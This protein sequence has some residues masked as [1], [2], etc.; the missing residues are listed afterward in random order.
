VAKS[1]SCLL[2]SARQSSLSRS[3][4]VLPLIRGKDKDMGIA[5]EG[6]DGLEL[7]WG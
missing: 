2:A 5:P 7:K 3:T 6:V 4:V 1:G